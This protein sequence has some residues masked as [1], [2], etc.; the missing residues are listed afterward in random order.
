MQP[1]ASPRAPSAGPV[2]RQTAP[3]P[4]PLHLA[5]PRIWRPRRHRLIRSARLC[6]STA[7]SKR[8]LADALHPGRLALS[9]HPRCLASHAIRC[10][11]LRTLARQPW[12]VGGRP[13]SS[14]TRPSA[15]SSPPPPSLPPRGDQW[16]LT[17]AVK[18]R[19][20]PSLSIR[21]LAAASASRAR[22]CGPSKPILRVGHG[23]D[24]PSAATLLGESRRRYLAEGRRPPR[25]RCRAKCLGGDR[26]SFSSL[27]NKCRP[28]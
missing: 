13:D 23:Q 6:G 7:V 9:P 20:S 16:P 25:R 3:N 19:S 24:L 15:I 21:A 27:N 22:R 4:R 12:R 26:S 28:T 10:S 5:T 14:T 2:P 18:R 8:L 17:H 1:N 11:T